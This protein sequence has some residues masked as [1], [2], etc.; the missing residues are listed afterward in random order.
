MAIE[1]RTYHRPLDGNGKLETWSNVVDRV[2]S[3]QRWLWVRAKGQP[4]NSIEMDEL[5]ELHHHTLHSTPN[6][7]GFGNSGNS[8]FPFRGIEIALHADGSL[9][10]VFLT[11]RGEVVVRKPGMQPVGVNIGGRGD[12]GV[13]VFRVMRFLFSVLKSVGAGRTALTKALVK[14]FNKRALEL[15]TALDKSER[16]RRGATRKAANF[17]NESNDGDGGDSEVEYDAGRDTSDDRVW[18][19]KEERRKKRAKAKP[20]K[21]RGR[22]SGPDEYIDG[23]DDDIDNGGGGDEGGDDDDGGGGPGSRASA[24]FI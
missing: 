1:L 11:T 19:A 7:S 16:P 24:Y 5:S 15:W 17:Y 4:L 18:K 10:S 22:R 21:P 14:E 8:L 12:G 6:P 13:I 9:A 3:H 23:E 2:V 20:K